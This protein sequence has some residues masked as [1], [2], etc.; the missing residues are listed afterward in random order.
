MQFLLFGPLI[1]LLSKQNCTKSTN[2]QDRPV[3]ILEKDKKPV[4]S[5]YPGYV[6]VM[7]S[8][9]Q[10]SLSDLT[11]LAAL[12]FLSTLHTKEIYYGTHLKSK[13]T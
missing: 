4:S 9:P 3:S 2:S 10:Q 1:A 8:T 13:T 7:L 11:G 6:T 5:G 12:L